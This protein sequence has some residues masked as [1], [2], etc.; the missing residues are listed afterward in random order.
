MKNLLLLLIIGFAAYGGYSMWSNHRETISPAKVAEAK[1]EEPAPNLQK[2]PTPAPAPESPKVE[3]EKPKVQAELPMP[4]APVKRLAPEGV[5]YAIQAF[6]IS[7]ED[8]I[9]GIRAGT[10]VRLIKDGGATLR[11]TDGKQEFDAKREHLTND[12]D[13][14]AQ[15]SGQ[16]ASQ[17]AAIAEWQQK[18]QALVAVNNQQKATDVAASAAIGQQVA[19]SARAAAEQRTQRMAEIRAQISSEEAQKDK[20][21]K[22]N[23]ITFQKHLD[24][25]NEKIRLLQ[26]ELGKLGVAGAAIQR[27]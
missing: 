12:L 22:P 15:A 1:T 5:F 16:Q 13:V 25:Q 8:G 9:R 27:R 21:F 17:Q 10:P 11:V 3:P 2:V 20:R 18:Q 24:I 6:S 23:Q 19:E 26:L 4:V 14:A 7:T